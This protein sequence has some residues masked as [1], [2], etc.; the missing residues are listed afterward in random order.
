MYCFSA[1]DFWFR[2]SSSCFFIS[3]ICSV[4]NSLFF[5]SKFQR[6]PTGD[7]KCTSLSPP[8]TSSFSCVEGSFDV[9]IFSAGYLILIWQ[10]VTGSYSA[11]SLSLASQVLLMISS[12][13]IDST[14]AVTISNLHFFQKSRK[15]LFFSFSSKTLLSF[16]TGNLRVYASS[17]KLLAAKISA[18]IFLVS[19]ALMN[20]S[21]ADKS[22]KHCGIIFTLKSSFQVG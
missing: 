16:H 4:V 13:G 10:V 18:G 14:F 5:F 19:C 12:S 2:I 3:S 11:I 21:D 15:T 22:N 8:S 1:S 6:Y 9:Y 7:F 17:F 20:S